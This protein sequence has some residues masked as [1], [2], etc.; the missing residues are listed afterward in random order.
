M[1]KAGLTEASI[2]YYLP[3]GRAFAVIEGGAQAVWLSTLGAQIDE[4][5]AAIDSAID[6]F[7]PTKTRAQYADWCAV[8]GLTV[9]MP[10]ADLLRRLR[11]AGLPF[12]DSSPA[13]IDVIASACQSAGYQVGITRLERPVFGQL[14]GK[15]FWCGGTLIVNL[16]TAVAGVKA[17]FGGPY[18]GPYALL[19]GRITEISALLTRLAPARFSIYLQYTDKFGVPGGFY[20]H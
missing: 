15:S 9:Q 8:A 10:R 7:Y 1:L 13:A 4:L 6:D 2:R 17:V 5:I 11:P 20:I 12:A 18:G 19:Y 14:Y 16:I 3:N